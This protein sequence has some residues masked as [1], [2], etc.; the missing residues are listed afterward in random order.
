MKRN[1][2]S[3]SVL[4]LAFLLSGC[5]HEIDVFTGGFTEGT[6]KG[7]SLF[8]LNE[9][10]GKLRLLS[11]IDA[12]PS[13][14]WI[15][16][17]NRHDLIYALNE[18]NDFDGDSSGGITVLEYDPETSAVKKKNEIAVPYGGPCHFSLTADEMF[19]LV[20]SYSSGSVAVVKLSE[21]G[22]PERITHTILYE[23]EGEN[24]SH[25][26][27]ISHDP[28]SKHI[29]LTDLGLDRLLVYDLDRAE[30]K[31]I[32][33]PGATVDLPAGSG[34]RHFVFNSEGSRMYVINEPGSSIMVFSISESGLPESLL[35]TVSTLDENFSGKNNCAEILLGK[36]GKYL[37]GSNRGEN[38]IVTYNVDDEGLLALAGRTDC[39][40]D[41]PRNFGIDPS[42]RYLL[43]GNQRSDNI[44]VFRIDSK[45][46]LP[47]VP[48]SVA[49]MKSP[50]FTGFRN[51]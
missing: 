15:C 47:G 44:S 26:H 25:P 9:N 24:V 50:A 36:D 28:S 45:T 34:P 37:Y 11:Q 23:A 49:P 20:A 51:K 10:T 30:G 29:Y 31:L 21:N 7:M 1:L 48:V 18:V 38:T 8:R 2:I 32:P 42:G 22:M 46:G 33:V 13:P 27:M 16:F 19:L 35:Q 5:R 14:A 12:G 4:I 17:S 43:C 41:W 39:G 40:G 6:E 3:L